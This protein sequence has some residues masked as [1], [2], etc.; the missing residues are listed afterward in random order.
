MSIT[1]LMSWR[2]IFIPVPQIEVYLIVILLRLLTELLAFRGIR[3]WYCCR[4]FA[5]HRAGT[6]N[7]SRC[8]S[9]F[10]GSWCWFRCVVLV[11]GRVLSAKSVIGVKARINEDRIVAA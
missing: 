5:L 8:W 1:L 6:V 4:F 2:A 7:H 3:L 10:G 11:P 9:N